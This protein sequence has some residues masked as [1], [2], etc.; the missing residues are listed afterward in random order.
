MKIEISKQIDFF[1]ISHIFHQFSHDLSVLKSIFCMN[2][3][4]YEREC[5]LIRCKFP[6]FPQNVKHI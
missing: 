1:V 2:E 5:L 3:L 4:P 6:K